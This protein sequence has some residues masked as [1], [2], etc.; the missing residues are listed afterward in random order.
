MKHW[1]GNVQQFTV[2]MKEAKC[3]STLKNAL[4]VFKPVMMDFQQKHSAY[5]FQIAVSIVFQ[6]VVDPAVVTEPPVVQ[7]LEM[8]D[9]YADA[10][11]PQWCESS[12][13]KFHRSVWRMV[14]DVF[15]LIFFPCNCHY[16]TLIH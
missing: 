14:Q 7:T 11:P 12:T 4:A 16:G 6:K 1:E 13:V 10:L 5:N 2:N 15:F 3:L 8:V 9:V